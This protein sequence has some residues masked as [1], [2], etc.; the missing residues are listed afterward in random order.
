MTLT[1]VKV[2]S[3]CLQPNLE[4]M[5]IPSSFS[6]VR[7]KTSNKHND[8]EEA[9]ASD[10]RKLAGIHYMITFFFRV[11]GA[12][13]FCVLNTSG[14]VSDAIAGR[15]SDETIGATGGTGLGGGRL[16]SL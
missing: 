10:S 3:T 14:I 5:I 2:C 1:M 4:I 12:F 16:V 11:A 9:D 7:Y 15:I 8:H 13:F 6:N